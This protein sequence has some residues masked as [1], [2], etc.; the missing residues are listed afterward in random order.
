MIAEVMTADDATTE[1]VEALQRNQGPFP[2]PVCDFPI[3][4]VESFCRHLH[5]AHRRLWNERWVWLVGG[6]DARTFALGELGQGFTPP[7]GLAG[8]S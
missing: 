4:D 1:L 5:G 2:C 6:T 3:P 7:L 8:E